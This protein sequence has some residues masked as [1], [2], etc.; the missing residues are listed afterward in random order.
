MQERKDFK[1]ALAED[2]FAAQARDALHRVVPGDEAEF[3]IEREDAIDARVEE[4][5]Q[6]V[7]GNTLQSQGNKTDRV[8]F[9]R[10]TVGGVCLRLYSV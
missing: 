3:A 8:D 4:A 9:P 10:W 5:A 6:Q 7:W 2:F 1:G